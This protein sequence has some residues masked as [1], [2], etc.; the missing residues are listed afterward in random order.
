MA[1][2]G[3]PDSSS[4]SD[5]LVLALPDRGILI[6][7]WISYSFNNDFLTPTDA[8]HFETAGKNLSPAIIDSL[9]CGARVQLRIN[10]HTQASGFIDVVDTHYE[11]GVGT[12]Y[13]ISGRDVFGPVVDSGADP[14]LYTFLPTM[15]LDQVIQQVFG[16]FGFTDP[17]QFVISNDANRTIQTG[18][19]TVGAKGKPLK[20]TKLA[21]QLQPQPGEG[22]FQYVARFLHRFGVW[23]WPSADGSQVI[24][25]VPNYDSGN[26]FNLVRSATGLT[27]NIIGG[28]VRE[29]ATDQPS[30]ILATGTSYGDSN[31]K[32]V[33]K[34]ILVNELTGLV[35]DQTSDSTEMVPIGNVLGLISRYPEAK[36]IDPRSVF[37]GYLKTLGREDPIA[38]PM[39]LHDE[40]S[41]NIDELKAFA[42]R[43]LSLRQQRMWTAQ[44]TVAGHTQNGAPWAVDTMVQVDD[45][46]GRGLH[47]PMYVRGRTFEKSRQGGTTTK[48][49]LVLPHTIDLGSG[50]DNS[51]SGQVTIPTTTNVGTPQVGATI[52]PQS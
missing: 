51:V 24:V 48:L 9:Y 42:Y 38:R 33:L 6:D 49:S 41:K 15:T 44:Y 52:V 25:S 37:Q 35:V 8:W 7:R 40:E 47:G 34:V 46:E 14:R 20:A 31:A 23:C 39:F 10:G 36:Y 22:M 45:D 26:S 5:E 18:I 16:Q 2:P 11:R 12:V 3:Y 50:F 29:D 4:L 43:E 19:K 13:T 28:G 17:S 30:A 1:L 21:K 32:T 27:S